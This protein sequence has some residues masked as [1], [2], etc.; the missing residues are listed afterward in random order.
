MPAFATW[1]ATAATISPVVAGRSIHGLAF[2]DDGVFLAM[3]DAAGSLGIWENDLGGNERRLASLGPPP[4]GQ[5]AA[6]APTRDGAHLW[7]RQEAFAPGTYLAS[8][9]DGWQKQ[10]VTFGFIDVLTARPSPVGYYNGTA[11]MVVQV[12]DASSGR[13]VEIES[14]DGLAWTQLDTYK[15]AVTGLP[16]GAYLSPDGC[17]LVVNVQAGAFYELHAVMRDAG[18]DFRGPTT[19]LDTGSFGC[20]PSSPAMPTDLSSLWFAS[21]A[22]GLVQMR[23]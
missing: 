16:L 8:R 19:K 10:L 2:H 6:P 17:L 21:S 22:G 14:V 4:G 7:F 18:G 12:Q 9:A 15:L 13:F 3:R 23:P 11:R 5:L 20:C 1:T